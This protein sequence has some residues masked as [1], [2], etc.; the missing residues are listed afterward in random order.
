LERRVLVRLWEFCSTTIQ[1][2][3][4]KRGGQTSRDSPELED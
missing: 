1:L 2:A 4:H 3:N